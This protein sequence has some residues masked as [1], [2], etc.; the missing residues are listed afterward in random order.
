MSK[1]FP[2]TDP[3][4]GIVIKEDG[5][6]VLVNRK[7]QVEIKEPTFILRAKDCHAV[8]TL[9]QYANQC[10]NEEHVEAV[11]KRGIEF[12]EWRRVNIDKVKEPDTE[13]PYGD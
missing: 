8:N 9:L 7:T 4:Y 13:L 6:P 1:V 10:D 5:T 11:M 12:V 2:T 3:K